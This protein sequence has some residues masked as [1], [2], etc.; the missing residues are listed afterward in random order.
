MSQRASFRMPDRADKFTPKRYEGLRNIA[1]IEPIEGNCTHILEDGEY[2][3]KPF[4]STSRNRKKCDEH[5]HR[6]F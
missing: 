3:G 1:R 5:M 4:S 6:K 2:C